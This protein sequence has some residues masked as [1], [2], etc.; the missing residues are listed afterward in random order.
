MTGVGSYLPINKCSNEHL[1]NFV[2]TSDEWISKRS[3]IKNR[4]FVTDNE[5]TSDMSFFAANKAIENAEISKKNIDLIVL[6]TT[7][8]DNTF[9]STATLVQKKLEINAVSFDI[10]AVCAGFVFALS[11]A[12]SMMTEGNYK[13][14][15]V[16]GADTMSK[17]LD[18]NDRSTSVLFG[19][20]AGAVILQ[21]F[22]NT[23]CKYDDWGILSNVIHSDG[24]F[25]DLLKT[26]GGVSTNQKVGFIEMEG[27][28]VFKHAVDKLSSSL[29][30]ALIASNKNI[31]ELDYLVPHQANQRIILSVADRMKI[32]IS[33]V[34][35]TVKDHGNTSA[36]SI[37]LALENAINSNKILNGNLIGIQAIGGGL[38]WGAS[39]IRIGKP[40]NL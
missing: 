13:N 9:P 27:K 38:S 11:V 4:H 32:D 10:Q 24:Q 35:S 14:C 5:K 2:D 29:E 18:W 22:E 39:I 34:V 12:K 1:S 26:N 16:I 20:G 7:T 3:G 36:A 28:E 23:E 31:D 40:K 21:K 17:L 33:K 6:A 8:P 25:Y 30:E 15:L 37:P 19:D